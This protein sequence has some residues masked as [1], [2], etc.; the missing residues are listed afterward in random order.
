MPHISLS[1]LQTK[2]LDIFDSSRVEQVTEN[3]NELCVAENDHIDESVDEEEDYDDDDADDDEDEQNNIQQEP[4]KILPRS[5]LPLGYVEKHVG[6]SSALHTNGTH[7]NDEDCDDDNSSGQCRLRR[8][9]TPHHLKG[10]RI[11]SISK[12]QLDP[13]DM[14]DILMKHVQS[15]DNHEQMDQEQSNQIKLSISLIRQPSTGLGISIAGG[16][17]TNGSQHSD[18]EGKDEEEDGVYV[19][20]VISGAAAFK[21]GLN[22][23]DK[24]LRVSSRVNFFWLFGMA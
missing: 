5:S 12:S 9:D 11:N 14:K 4:P 3:L 21:S 18:D 23:G 15:A 24:L 10:A 2:T 20:K 17:T 22:V 1:T 6:F 16:R 8:H 13:V 19:T 7:S